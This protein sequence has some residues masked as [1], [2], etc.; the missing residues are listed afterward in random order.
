MQ[1]VIVIAYAAAALPLQFMCSSSWQCIQ[2]KQLV[3]QSPSGLLLQAQQRCHFHLCAHPQGDACKSSSWCLKP[4][5][6]VAA[7]PRVNPETR[8]GAELAHA[9]WFDNQE[10]TLEFLLKAGLEPEQSSTGAWQLILHRSLKVDSQAASFRQ[11]SA[12]LCDQ[13]AAIRCQSVS[14]ACTCSHY[15]LHHHPLHFRPLYFHPLHFH[16][17]PGHC[18]LSS[19]HLSL[20][21]M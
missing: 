19:L 15:P 9:M 17:L 10:D 7:G 16:P 21:S 6:L 2:V 5:S 18:T 20:A 12:R 3:P 4:I 11:R 13:Q 14:L 1:H 8:P